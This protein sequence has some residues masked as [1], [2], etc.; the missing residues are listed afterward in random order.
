MADST[1]K[2]Q[3]FRLFAIYWPKDEYDSPIWT[4]RIA[5]ILSLIALLLAETVC[6]TNFWH[7]ILLG[8]V[9][10]QLMLTSAFA[11]QVKKINLRNPPED[12]GIQQLHL[13]R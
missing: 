12:A 2:S 4:L 13:T 6:K 1:L 5:P 8:Y 9:I 3:L 10:G 7:G 11:W